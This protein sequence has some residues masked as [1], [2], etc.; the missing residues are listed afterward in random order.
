MWETSRAVVMCR[1]VS[2]VD[3][4]LS[5]TKFVLHKDWDPKKWA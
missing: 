5:L 2:F 1:Y 4:V 3:G